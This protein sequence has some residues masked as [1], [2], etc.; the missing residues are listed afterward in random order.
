MPKRE[1]VRFFDT[2]EQAESAGFTP[3]KRCAPNTK[4]DQQ[5]DVVARACRFIEEAET[6]LTRVWTQIRKNAS[7][8]EAL[9]SAGYESS[10]RFYEKATAALGMKPME[11]RKGGSGMTIRYATVRCYLGW[12]LVAATERGICKIAFGD[13]PE[14]LRRVLEKDFPKAVLQDGGL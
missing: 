3:C 11:Y 13:T 1:N 5:T 14:F 2:W 12:A 10:S 7:V 9:Y 4:T 6:R 8:T